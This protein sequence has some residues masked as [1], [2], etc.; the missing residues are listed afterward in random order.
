MRVGITG[1]RG[2]PQ[3]LARTLRPELAAVISEYDAD[4]LVGVS[5]LA[6]GPDAWFARSVLDRGGRIEAVIPA[7]DY[8]AVSRRPIT[9]CTT[10]CSGAPR[11]CTGPDGARRS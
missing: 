2:L 1:H 4:G 5:C 6:D 8:R 10:N 9:L 7:E 3:D 11:W